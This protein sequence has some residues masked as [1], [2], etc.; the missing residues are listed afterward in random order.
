M[1]MYIYVNA[2]LQ[3]VCTCAGIYNILTYYV[4]VYMHIYTVDTQTHTHTYI[5]IYI[6]NHAHE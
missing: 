4:N 6:Y 3:Y 5:Y 2:C 1:G